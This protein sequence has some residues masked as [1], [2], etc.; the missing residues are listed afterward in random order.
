MRPHFHDRGQVELDQR[1]ALIG[2][3]L[4]FVREGRRIGH[5]LRAQLGVVGET[6]E[7]RCEL[8]QLGL[9]RGVVRGAMRLAVSAGPGQRGVVVMPARIHG[10]DIGLALA[11]RAGRAG[12]A[13]QLDIAGV[14]ELGLIVA[15]Q[16]FQVSALELFERAG[17][18]VELRIGIAVGAGKMRHAA[19]RQHHRLDPERRLQGAQLLA[20][21]GRHFP[22]VLDVLLVFGIGHSEEL[23]RMGQHGAAD[24]RRH[25]DLSPWPIPARASTLAPGRVAAQKYRAK[26]RTTRRPF[27]AEK[28]ASTLRRRLEFA[29]RC[30]APIPSQRKTGEETPMVEVPITIACGN[31]DRTRAIRDGRVKV[32][33]CEVTY[34]PLYPEE[35]FFRAF[36]YQEFDVSELSFSSYIRTV[37]AGNSAYVGIPAFV[38][39]LFRHSSIYVRT[40]AGIRAPADL[41]GKPIGLPEYQITAMA[42]MRGILQHEYGL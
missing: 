31:Y 36:R 40:D 32:E 5:V 19:A 24:H 41:T 7:H 27:T 16:R 26:Q 2:G 42:W 17:V 38:S 22:H 4:E 25:H 15:D 28:E 21:I 1:L 6:V 8:D 39:R 18:P 12:P 35:I 11:Q 33:G 20:D 37:A 9:D 34:L 30:L 3:K 14:V 23:R 29:F 13:A 10:H